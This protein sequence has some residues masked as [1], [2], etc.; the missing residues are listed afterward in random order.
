[1]TSLYGG[2]YMI[3]ATVHLGGPSQMPGGGGSNPYTEITSGGPGSYQGAC[4]GFTL[5]VRNNDGYMHMESEGWIGGK[6]TNEVYC[7]DKTGKP[8]PCTQSRQSVTGGGPLYGQT[9]RLQWVK[10]GGRYGG[11]ITGPN[12]S[13]GLA[14]APGNPRIGILSGG[15]GVAKDASRVR[16]DAAGLNATFDVKVSQL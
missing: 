9:V 10:Q 13:T 16:T 5:G 2:D 1:L 7:D 12:G 11:I 8:R 15:R 4:C 3:D 14:W 6:T